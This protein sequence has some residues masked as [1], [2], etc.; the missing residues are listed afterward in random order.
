MK[1][2]AHTVW[3]NDLLQYSLLL[4]EVL[5]DSLQPLCRSHGLTLQ[6]FRLLSAA[7]HRPNQTVGDL[8]ASTGILRTNMAAICRQL[9][10]RGFLH[11]VRD[12][13]DH[14]RIT[15]VLTDLGRSTL[16]QIESEF[17]HRYQAIFDAEPRETFD[18]IQA[19]MEALRRFSRKLEGSK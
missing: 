4:Q 3:K 7:E 11:R 13:I 8:S 9:E 5:Q 10:M 12:R 17:H 14:R 1:H 2:S 15:L 6:Q 19:G 18:A 16:H